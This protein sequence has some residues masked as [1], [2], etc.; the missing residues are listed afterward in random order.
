MEVP[1]YQVDAFTSRLFGGNPAA[2]CPLDHWL[3]ESTLQSIA[4]E[5]N[6]AET[7]YFVPEGDGFHLRWFTPAVEVALCGHATLASAYVLMNIL[8]PGRREVRFRTLSGNLFVTR[9]GDRFTLD[10]PAQPPVRIDAPRDLV[11]ALGK[12]PLEVWSARDT[13]TRSGAGR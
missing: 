7:A 9:D 3:D 13:P 5:N 8:E 4:G 11:D 6:L 10:F 2:V 1:F 12:E